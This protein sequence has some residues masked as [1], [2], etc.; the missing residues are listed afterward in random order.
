VR[1]ILSDNVLG[2]LTSVTLHGAS[3]LDLPAGRVCD[4]AGDLRMSVSAYAALLADEHDDGLYLVQV[5]RSEFCDR[6]M[7]HMQQLWQLLELRARQVLRTA[8]IS[9]VDI[10]VQSSGGAVAST[11]VESQESRNAELL[12]G[13]GS[14]TP[15]AQQ[16]LQRPLELDSAGYGWVLDL[17]FCLIVKPVAQLAYQKVARARGFGSQSDVCAGAP[18]RA[19]GLAA[20]VRRG[21]LGRAADWRHTHGARPAHGRQRS[22]KALRRGVSSPRGRSGDS[23]CEP[24]RRL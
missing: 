7:A 17:L 21:L 2:V 24:V 3:V 1:A 12:W 11:A 23:Q 16:L 10:V 22:T 15:L 18:R 20:R 4:S 9:C 5:L 19:T 8:P 6:L 14:D 13:V